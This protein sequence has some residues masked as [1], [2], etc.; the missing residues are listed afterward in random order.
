[1][2]DDSVAYFYLLRSKLP[3]AEARLEG[4]NGNFWLDFIHKHS[5]VA[6]PLETK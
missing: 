1:M 4:S 6:L 3:Q 5:R 2:H